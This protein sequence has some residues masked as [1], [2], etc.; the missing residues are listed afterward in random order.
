[1]QI[2]K[3]TLL[4]LSLIITLFLSACNDIEKIQKS[5]DFEYK[6]TKANEFYDK[7]QW[8]NANTLYEELLTVF[9]GTKNFEAIYY[10]YANTFYNLKDYLAASYHYKNFTDIFPNSDK[11]E[12][13]EYLTCLCL[14]KNSNDADLDQT[15]TI[16]AIGALQTFLNNHPES[17]KADEA[18]KI[19][20]E[21]RAKLE[22][23][24]AK[25]AY[26]YYKISQFKAAA[27]AYAGLLKKFPDSK[28]ADFYQFMI[29]QSN[30]EYSKL[31]VADKQVERY[32]QCLVDYNDLITNYPNSK[33][34][35]DALK[36][37]STIFAALEKF[38]KS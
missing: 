29:F 7:G 10:K 11:N 20:D 37:K 9:K 4:A 24:D 32:N 34:K 5:K 25:S 36:I 21:G 16:Q 6:L 27:T 30:Y 15:N 35:N 13:C 23:K 33:Y 38:K 17:P 14:Y 31:S 26:L 1:M 12:E 28:Q 18:N 19:M 3:K 8:Q 2:L 22:V